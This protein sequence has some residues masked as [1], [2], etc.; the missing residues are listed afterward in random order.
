MMLDNRLIR[1]DVG[2]FPNGKWNWYIQIL[3]RR[4][5]ALEIGNSRWCETGKVAWWKITKVVL[6]VQA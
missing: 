4:K 2:R 5:K 6:G 3:Y 1:A